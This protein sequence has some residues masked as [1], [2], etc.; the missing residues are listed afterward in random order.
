MKLCQRFLLLAVR[1]FLPF[2]RGQSIS[3]PA[4]TE[5]SHRLLRPFDHE[6]RA[7]LRL[8]ARPLYTARQ[9]IRRGLFPDGRYPQTYQV[10]ERCLIDARFIIDTLSIALT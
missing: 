4:S 6:R 10:Y 1:W 5:S 3:I 2:N 8:R 7:S 9:P